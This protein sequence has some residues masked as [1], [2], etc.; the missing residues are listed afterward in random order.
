MMKYYQPSLFIEGE[1]DKNYNDDRWSKKLW[2]N[3]CIAYFQA[4]KGKKKKKAVSDFDQHRE[5]HLRQLHHELLTGTYTISASTCF[6][7][8]D[9]VQREVF[10][11]DFR[12]RIVHHLLYNYLAPIREKL[13]IFDSYSCRVGKGTHFGIQRVKR[14]MRACSE[15]FTKEARIL[16]LDVKG[17]LA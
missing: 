7:I 16:K 17:L 8:K 9:P 11:A 13:F 2:Q 5:T 1:M 10:A 12:D 6:I 4:C 15:N 14:F 3:L